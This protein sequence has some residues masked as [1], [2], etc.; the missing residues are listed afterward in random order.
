MK[1]YE[2]IIITIL[3]IIIIYHLYYNN[4]IETMLTSKDCNHNINDIII[5]ERP[6]PNIKLIDKLVTK[7]PYLFNNDENKQQIT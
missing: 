3:I 4:N 5:I 6:I 1:F 7:Y 2:I